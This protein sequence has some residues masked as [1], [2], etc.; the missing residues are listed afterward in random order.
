MIYMSALAAL[1]GISIAVVNALISAVMQITVPQEM[2]GKVFGLLG[3]MAGS[4]MP[5]ALAAG[6]WLGE[7]FPLRPLMTG[8]FILTFW[9][10]F[11]LAFVPPVIRFFNYD[12]QKQTLEDII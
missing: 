12:P 10:F 6:G 11:I 1:I 2:R 8:C 5:V 9:A 7:I 3:T 4:L